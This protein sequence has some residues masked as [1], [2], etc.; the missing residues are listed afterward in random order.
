MGILHGADLN[1]KVQASSHQLAFTT[2]TT[3]NYNNNSNNIYLFIRE[4][5][6][7]ADSLRFASPF[8]Q[9]KFATN[10]ILPLISSKEKSLS[11]RRFPLW[12][13][14]DSQLQRI[15]LYHISVPASTAKSQTGRRYSQELQEGL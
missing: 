11:D 12:C 15:L 14:N 7:K 8:E 6:G 13:A 10:Y 3:T 2:T 5:Q 9:A 4:L 1:L